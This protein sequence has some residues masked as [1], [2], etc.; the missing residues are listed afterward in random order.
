MRTLRS[1]L[2]KAVPL[3]AGVAAVTAVAWLRPGAPRPSAITSAAVTAAA[4]PP[5]S[6][7][8]GAGSPSATPSETP[9]VPIV[10][11]GRGGGLMC[12]PDDPRC[13]PVERPL[14]V[15]VDPPAPAPAAPPATAAA[16]PGDGAG[17]DITADLRRMSD[18]SDQ[19]RIAA[20]QALSAS[21]DPR[22]VT[23]LV[24][25][26]TKD[27]EPA[28]RREAALA[29]GKVLDERIASDVREIA[30]DALARVATSDPDLEVCITADRV[31]QMLAGL[32]RKKPH[33]GTA[34]R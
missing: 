12:D 11:P 27:A 31:Q 2:L 22:A 15:H 34:A 25:A 4:P 26:L 13:I 14:L 30:L 19:V 10:D 5:Q 28:V 7:A 24:T 18:A 20:A 23:A 1:K 17:I 32:P 6:V 8:A 33:P 16:S 3:L 29:L 21:H 9:P